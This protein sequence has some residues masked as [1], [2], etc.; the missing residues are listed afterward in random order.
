MKAHLVQFSVVVVG[1]T[2]NPS[3][4]NPDFL[5]INEIVPR[6]WKW[7]VDQTITT[8]PLAMVRYKNGVVVVVEPNKLQVVDTSDKQE[9]SSSRIV[10]IA[11]RYTETLPHVRYTAVGINFHS[12]AERTM[13]GEFLKEQFVKSGPWDS[14]DHPLKAVGLR[15][16]YP[17]DEG[18]LILSLDAG[19]VEKAEEGSPK[20]ATVL[21]VRGN[22]HRDCHDYPA[23]NKV[24]SFLGHAEADWSFY[25]KVLVDVLA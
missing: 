6:E 13:P 23:T 16:V 22:F 2:H 5:A 19:E 17:I 14:I 3:I 25:E 4:L 9:P 1:R 15:F 20:T 12:I 18:R 21:F 11:T 24:S 8:P 10:A 7:E